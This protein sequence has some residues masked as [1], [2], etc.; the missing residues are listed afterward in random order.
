LVGS[1]ASTARKAAR[2]SPLRLALAA[3]MPLFSSLFSSSIADL[4]TKV[5]K[6]R[7]ELRDPCVPLVV[8]RGYCI[9]KWREGNIC[10]V[11]GVS[12]NRRSPGS[13]AV[14]GLAEVAQGA[15]SAL[16]PR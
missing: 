13:Q 2:A 8:L 9:A 14:N 5:R 12:Q 10:P 15:G 7:N 3:A 1:S 4:S 16:C 6:T 11:L